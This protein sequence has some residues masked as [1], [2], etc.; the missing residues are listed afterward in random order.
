MAVINYRKFKV[1]ID[2][3]S[4]KVQG[5]REGDIVRRL[6]FEGDTAVYTLMCVLGYGVDAEVDSVTER[7]SHRPYF[8]GALLEGD[9]PESGQILDFIR[10]T[11]LYDPDRG[12]AFFLNSLGQHHT[13]A[14]V[15]DDIGK[16]CSMCWPTGMLVESGADPSRQYVP[17]D[18]TSAEYLSVLEG[19]RR[20]CHIIGTRTSDPIGST[21]GITQEFYQNLA[22]G[23][24][25][26]ISYKVKAV[27]NLE[28]H[29]TFG[30]FDLVGE[31]LSESYTV[32]DDWT[33]H[34]HVVGIENPGRLLRTF[35]LSFDGFVGSDEVMVAGLNIIQLSSLSSFSDQSL[36]RMGRL[37]GTRD[38]VFGQSKGYG[39]H[40]RR[41]FAT[42]ASHVSGTLTPGDANGFGSTF[43]AGRIHRNAFVNSIEPTFVGNVPTS[44][45]VSDPTGTSLVNKLTGA[46]TMVAQSALWLANRVGLEY[47]FSFWAYANKACEIAIKQN[48]TLVGTVQIG[49]SDIDKWLRI[50]VT[51]NLVSGCDGL[52]LEI[53]P[54]FDYVQVNERSIE[55]L[56]V[57]APQLEVGDTV[58][59]YQPT[60]DTLDYTEEFGAWFNRGGLGGTIQHPL[61][62]LNYDGE[63][64]IGTIGDAVEIR[65]DGSGH[66]AQGN[67]SWDDEGNVAFGEG[68]HSW[69]NM[70]DKPEILDISMERIPGHTNYQM[71]LFYRQY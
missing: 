20:V 63:G 11:N 26:L 35:G 24:M 3:D 14:E 61:L 46:A 53:D 23:D 59:Q 48:G 9:A 66:I 10:V 4:P 54:S 16:S 19:N 55:V 8:I 41:M 21:V 32:T 31:P 36:V 2:A 39:G 30:A 71:R 34:L 22:E 15:I 18:N 47:S 37:E 17:N 57:V 33:Y 42:G 60:D 50:G 25:I 5:L 56:Y 69:N 43:Y 45:E 38:I 28:A 44:D 49:E 62:K 6:Y 51:F 27:R 1:S 70:E 68:V 7:V 67:I 40:F 29:A 12:G 52:L 13:S 58:T 64:S 65:P